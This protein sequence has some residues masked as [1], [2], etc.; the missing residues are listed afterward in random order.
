MSDYTKSEVALSPT[1][2]LFIRFPGWAQWVRIS[3]AEFRYLGAQGLNWNKPP[4]DAKLMHA[5]GEMVRDDAQVEAA[6]HIRAFLFARSGMPSLDRETVAGVGT[7]D[8]ILNLQVADLE[9]LVQSFLGPHA[10]TS[11]PP[12]GVSRLPDGLTWKEVHR[13][14]AAG[15]QAK[16]DDDE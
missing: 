7:S 3:E 8:G 12:R 11:Q 15:A 6:E 9:I 5:Q 14:E 2:A 13:R 16:G 1:G 10:A 4:V